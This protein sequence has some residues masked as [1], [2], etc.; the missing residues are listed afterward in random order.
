MKK[1]T[2]P[3]DQALATQVLLSPA[4]VWRAGLVIA[5]LV[6]LALFIRFVLTDAGSL[7][8]ALVMAWFISLAMEPAVRRLSGHMR[9]ATAAL[10]VIAVFVLVTVIF[11]ILFGNLFVQQVAQLL[12]ALPGV[13]VGA[14]DWL[15]ARL[16]TRYQAS[17]ILASIDLTP[18]QAAHYAQGVLNGVL[19]LLGTVAGAVFN[20]VT[21]L[22]LT[23]YLSAD[24]PR[25]RQWIARLLP[26]RVRQVFISVWDEALVKTGG[27][28]SSRLIL[29]TIN[30]AASTLVFVLLGL[31]SWLALGIW[32]GVAAQFVP[33]IGTY[34]SIILPVVVGLA[35]PRPWLGAAVLAWGVLYQQVEN[36]TLEPRISARSVDIHPGVSFAAVI[37]G[38]SL[39]GAVGALLA[40]PVVAM[41]LSLVDTF[42]THQEPQVAQAGTARPPVGPDTAKPRTETAKPDAGP[43]REDSLCPRARAE[44]QKAGRT[45]LKAQKLRSILV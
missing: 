4:N 21:T 19:G 13:I 38:A 30:S 27:Y 26:G 14:V 8:V 42:V 3:R 7:V 25:L 24:G 9:R 40:I 11:L 32:T 44:V 5:A 33:T 15:N 35:S 17:G 10:V 45:A 6:A 36:L 1:P 31:P 34:I 18:Q 41:L 29:A 28:V 23:F 16:G 43:R 12:R 20:V 2:Q 37:L 39:F 22:L